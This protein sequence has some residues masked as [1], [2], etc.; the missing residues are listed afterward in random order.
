MNWKIIKTQTPLKNSHF[1]II[2][3]KCLKKNNAIVDNY[4]T[5]NLQDVAIVGAFTSKNE[6]VLINEY[7]HPVKSN[8]IELPAGF[9]EK[10][11]NIKQTAAR[12][13]LEETG[14]KAEKMIKIH[15]AF[16]SAGLLS[17]KIHFF[18]G[19]NAKKVGL[20][21]LDQNEEIKVVVTKWEK[22]LLYLKQKK[23]KDM[24]SVTAILL[25]KDY[26]KNKK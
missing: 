6:I 8:D 17:N 3:E 25:I 18:I 1:K 9:M 5:V 16:S 24:A 11:E 10:N 4:Y 21:K 19:T 22:A 14:Y 7:R 2:K 12:E 20:Q 13:L 23:I 15:E 26:I